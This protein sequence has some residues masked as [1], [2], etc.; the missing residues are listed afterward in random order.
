MARLAQRTPECRRSRLLA[1]PARRWRSM[2]WPRHRQR[3]RKSADRPAPRSSAA[4]RR[5]AGD[6]RLDLLVGLV[7]ALEHGCGDRRRDDRDGPT[8][9]AAAASR[10]RRRSGSAMSSS[11]G[12]SRPI[13]CL[14]S[15]AGTIRRSPP[16]SG[17]AQFLAPGT[18]CSPTSPVLRG[19]RRS[20]RPPGRGDPMR[21]VT[22]LRTSE[23]ALE[24]DD[25]TVPGVA[26]E[27]SPPR[28]VCSPGRPMTLASA[29]PRVRR[30]SPTGHRP[31]RRTSRPHRA[32]LLHERLGR[33]RRAA[34][35]Q[36]GDR[37]PSSG[38]RAHPTRTDP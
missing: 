8:P 22:R 20:R 7:E 31:P 23:L 30:P 24:L 28:P 14:L 13:S 6:P 38:R 4:P 5:A 18:T 2:S 32:G 21:R 16:G 37:R 36:E 26:R 33:Y 12:P 1:R 19:R 17:R 35:D 3:S 15:A 27:T 11:P 10:R 25:R 29:D 9:G 34:G